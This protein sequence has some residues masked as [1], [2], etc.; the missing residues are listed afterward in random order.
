MV[1]D[2]PSADWK[3]YDAAV[4]RS[5]W[6]Y[7]LSPASFASWLARVEAAGLPL[8]NPPAV[9]RANWDKTYLRALEGAGV[10]TAPTIWVEKGSS[11]SLDSLLAE[12]GWTEAVVKPVVSAGAFRTSRARRGDP[13]GRRRCARCSRTP[14]R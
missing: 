14:A 5:A 3:K 7:H 9:V 11:V 1:W 6:D 2:D 4:I 8:W 12:R 10:G 13:Q